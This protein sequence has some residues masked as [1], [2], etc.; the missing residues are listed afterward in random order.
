[1]G[2]INSEN[3]FEVK[4]LKKDTAITIEITDNLHERLQN[5]LLGGLAFENVEIMQKTLSQIK[6]SAVDPD[7]ITY[8]ARTLISL[9]SLIEDAAKQQDKLES[10]FIDK[11]TGK[12][13]SED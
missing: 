7:P 10:K 1:M 5:L 11:K 3:C 13:I 6:N 4:C 2:K 12:P 9:I 8:H